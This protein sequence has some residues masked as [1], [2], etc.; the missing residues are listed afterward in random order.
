MR[1]SNCSDSSMSEVLAACIA[2]RTI[3][4]LETSAFLLAEPWP[5]D[6]G[7]VL[8]RPVSAQVEF[9]GPRTGRLE[10]RCPESLLPL[11]ASNMLCSE[12]PSMALQLDAFGE[13]ANIICGNVLPF[14]SETDAFR[15]SAPRVGPASHTLPAEPTAAAS[16][17]MVGEWEVTVALVLDEAP[18]VVT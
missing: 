18:A 8:E 3:H 16:R 15:L 6:G 11:L 17:L 14:V 2:D 4:A 1:F 10:V 13:L 7:H 12:E 9:R 5:A